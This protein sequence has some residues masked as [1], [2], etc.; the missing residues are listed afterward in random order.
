[1]AY[2]DRTH[3]TH[4][5]YDQPMGMEPLNRTPRTGGGVA[6][7]GAALGLVLLVI[8]GVSFLGGDGGDTAPQTAPAATE[9]GAPASDGVSAPV[10]PTGTADG[11]QQQPAPAAGE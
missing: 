2:S 7:L 3:P 9:Q 6:G 1:M 11:T 4:D 10:A 5:P 8:V